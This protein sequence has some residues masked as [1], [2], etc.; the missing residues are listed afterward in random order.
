MAN[1]GNIDDTYTFTLRDFSKFKQGISQ[2]FGPE[3]MD[4]N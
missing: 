4:D 3:S 1:K 2:V